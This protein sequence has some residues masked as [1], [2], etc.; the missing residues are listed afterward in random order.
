ETAL[1]TYEEERP[2][3]IPPGS[4]AAGASVLLALGTSIKDASAAMWH[5]VGRRF[6]EIEF[7]FST[8]VQP[9][10]RQIPNNS[11]CI[12]LF[13]KKPLKREST[14]KVRITY[15]DHADEKHVYEWIF[16]TE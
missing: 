3:P 10:H 4:G 5:K 7:H 12:A 6:R 9:A 14:Y 16:M 13:P 1:T 11:R 8:P 2:D 15:T